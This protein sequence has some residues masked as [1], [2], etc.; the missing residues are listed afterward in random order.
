MVLRCDDQWRVTIRCGFVSPCAGTQECFDGTCVV[1][2]RRDRHSRP[3]IVQ[4]ARTC[5]IDTR[6]HPH[7][8]DFQTT[9]SSGIAQK[10]RDLRVSR[11]SGYIQHR[12]T[13]CVRIVE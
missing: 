13:V 1:A 7:H 12:P 2:T 9:S 6:L 8:R 10:P 4:L 5:R 3:V 11:L